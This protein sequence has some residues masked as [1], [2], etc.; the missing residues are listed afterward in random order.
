MS[1]CLYQKLSG[2]DGCLC[3][4]GRMQRRL[5]GGCL[6]VLFLSPFS[7]P[8]SGRGAVGGIGLE[9]R[10]LVGD[11]SGPRHVVH[12]RST[13]KQTVVLRLQTTEVYRLQFAF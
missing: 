10:G 2:K 9:F 3:S 1:V 5:D 7:A 13:E 8:C 4:E 6:K 12:G 11:D